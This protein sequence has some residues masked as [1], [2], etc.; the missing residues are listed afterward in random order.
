MRRRAQK[1]EWQRVLMVRTFLLLDALVLTSPRK[2]PE[3]YNSHEWGRAYTYFGEKKIK[4]FTTIDELFFVRLCGLFK[5]EIK[6]YTQDGARTDEWAF[7]GDYGLLATRVNQ[8]L[9]VVLL[10]TA[11]ATPQAR[12]ETTESVR[13]GPDSMAFIDEKLF[14]PH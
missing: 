11:T 14:T 4:S 3:L 8:L 7:P 10:M 9:G 13:L 2:G 5:Q 12:L 1:M 6:Y